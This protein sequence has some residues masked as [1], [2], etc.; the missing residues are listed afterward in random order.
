[1]VKDMSDSLR[2]LVSDK[3]IKSSER[4]RAR[5]EQD[6][7][8]YLANGGEIYQANQGESGTRRDYYMDSNLRASARKGNKAAVDAN[9]LRGK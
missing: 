2:R 9:R 7:A 6:V 4:D 8:D 5:I 1:M 3:P